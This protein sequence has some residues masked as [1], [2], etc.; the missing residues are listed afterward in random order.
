MA[1]VERDRP[2][3]PV[4]ALEVDRVGTDL[5]G[6]HVP[7]N[8][9]ADGRILDLD[10]LGSEVGELH[11]AERPRTELLDRDDTNIAERA[12][13]RLPSP[14]ARPLAATW[15]AIFRDASSIISPSRSTAPTW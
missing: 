13:H 2:L 15:S 6:R 1:K 12:G 3:V 4:E 5:I 9:A 8:V 14:P 10:H 11:R 7:G